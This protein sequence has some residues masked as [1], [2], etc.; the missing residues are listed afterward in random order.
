MTYPYPLRLGPHLSSPSPLW[1]LICRPFPCGLGLY[2]SVSKAKWAKTLFLVNFYLVPH[3][4]PNPFQI[5]TFAA[6]SL[7]ETPLFLALQGILEASSPLSLSAAPCILFLLEFWLFKP[8]SLWIWILQ[9]LIWFARVL[10]AYI[11]LFFIQCRTHHLSY[12][13]HTPEFLSPSLPQPSFTTIH[14]FCP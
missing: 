14:I 4:K 12:S 8:F 3:H 5:W 13:F 1:I 7:L 6:P 9:V 2:K 11:Y 10:C